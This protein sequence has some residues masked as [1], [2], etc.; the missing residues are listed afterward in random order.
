MKLERSIGNLAKK[1][2]RLDPI[3]ASINKTSLSYWKNKPIISL[4]EWIRFRES[5]YAL[6]YFPD[7]FDQV[8][9]YIPENEL[10]KEKE[11]YCNQFLNS[12]LLT[13]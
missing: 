13:L 10:E 2:D 9:S 4:D 7:N 5:P 3:K 12:Q 8:L 6:D 1:L 11:K